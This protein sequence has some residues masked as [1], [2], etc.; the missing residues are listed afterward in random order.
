MA[1]I[2]QVDT[3]YILGKVLFVML[4]GYDEVQNTRDFG[5][6]GAVS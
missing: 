6:I 4:P 5:R 2:G 3:R 1:A